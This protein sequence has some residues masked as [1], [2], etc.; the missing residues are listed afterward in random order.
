[1]G[2]IEGFV[3][4]IIASIG[5]TSVLVSNL[6]YIGL[7]GGA[8]LG[9]QFLASSLLVQKPSVPRPEDGS[10]NLKQNVPSLPIVYGTVK[11]GGDYVFL[12]ETLGTAYHIIVWSGRRINGFTRH[13]L[14]DKPATLDGNG[15]VTDPAHFVA[16]TTKYVRLLTRLGLNASVAYAEVVSAFSVWT[17][18][19][20]GDGLASILMMCKTAPQA[21]YLKIFP[22]QM[23]E[24]SAIGE[25]ALLYDPRK[26]ST[27]PGGA[28]AHRWTNANT[29]EFSRNLALIRLDHLTKPY[30]GKLSY[31]DMYLPDVMAAADIADGNVVNRMGG[32]EKRWHGGIWFRANND[33][34][35]VGRQIDE[36]GEIVIYERFDGKIGMHPGS[37]VAPTVRLTAD[38]IFAIKV[39]KNRRKSATV[40]AVRGRY[41]NRSNHYNTE[42]AAIYGSPY[43]VLDDSTERTKT[44][45]NVCIQSHNHCQRKLKLTFNRANARQVTVTADYRAARGVAYS[46]FVRVHYPSR[47]LVEAII[48]IKGNVN[49]DLRNMRISFS[50]IIVSATLFDFNAATEE[51]VPGELI[52]P[53]PDAGVPVPTGFVA[54]IAT[55][56]VSGGGTAAFGQANW[57]FVDDSLVY[58]LEWE[59]TDL[60]EPARTAFSAPQKTQVRSMYLADGKEYRFR[61]RTWG[62]GS[63]SDWTAYQ[64]LT[65][66]AD[67]VAPAIVTGAGMVGGVGQT[68]FN[69]TA[70]NSA[71]YYAA[72][73]Y[74]NTSNTMTGATLVG[75]EYGAPAA[76][77][78]RSIGG[79]TAGTYYGFVQAINPS[80]V[81]ASAVATGSASVT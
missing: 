29:W 41:V 70:P 65:A 3:L 18:N 44:L 67:P 72:R 7:M 8:L 16:G 47:G 45:D 33:P 51:G 79:L 69:W 43:G 59:P 42:D 64:I 15:Y 22:N 61:L 13:Y 60:S 23:P 62:G 63:S 57:T 14:H 35:E 73:L 9:A 56:V 38:D 46:R 55:E 74:L 12:E 21:N 50:G 37:F 4:S 66:T 19:H 40:L 11:K 78:S 31:A 48:E 71:N 81:P 25:G 80:G 53:V 36:A 68:T 49:R 77:D 1:M 39:D 24:H 54:S 30:G 28:G 20:R 26:D 75:V 10:Y 5:T 6:L 52:E 34:I 58:E 2:I 76:P 32:T 27:Q 17:N